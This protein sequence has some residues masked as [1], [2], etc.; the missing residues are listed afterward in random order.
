MELHSY[1][2][3]NG[4]LKT[5]FAYRMVGMVSAWLGSL[6][7]STVALFSISLSHYLLT[8]S[9][10]IW[11]ISFRH[12]SDYYDWPVCARERMSK[13]A[14]ISAKR[15]PIRI[16]CNVCLRVLFTFCLRKNPV[17]FPMPVFYS[18]ILCYALHCFMQWTLWQLSACI[19]N[20]QIQT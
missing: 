4:P 6:S 14:H 20:A 1:I 16:K 18:S 17:H 3:R 12:C 5:H 8:A 15:Q 11:P 19:C 13:Q 10:H 9:I 7:H 2:W